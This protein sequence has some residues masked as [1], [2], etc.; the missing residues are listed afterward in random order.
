MGWLSTSA[1]EDDAFEV[2]RRM[3]QL[4]KK[5]QA[6]KEAHFAQQQRRPQHASVLDSLAKLAD[7]AQ[8]GDSAAVQA[9]RTEYDWKKAEAEKTLK[10]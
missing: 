6:A 5:R 3:R 2:D 10:Q 1:I 8:H 7:A 4:A 9:A